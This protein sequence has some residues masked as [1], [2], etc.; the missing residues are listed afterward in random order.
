M[1]MTDW[2]EAKWSASA[3]EGRRLHVKGRRRADLSAS[4][5]RPRTHAVF[6]PGVPAAEALGTRSRKC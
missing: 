5:S 1:A 6:A 2:T 4:V 3:V